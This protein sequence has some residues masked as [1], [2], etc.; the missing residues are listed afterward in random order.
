MNNPK[1]KLDIWK[2]SS[3]PVFKGLSSEVQDELLVHSNL[4]DQENCA[5]RITVQLERRGDG[6]VLC[7]ATV[8]YPVLQYIKCR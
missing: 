6:W 3:L 8:V 2:T 7:A 1:S 5:K 4:K